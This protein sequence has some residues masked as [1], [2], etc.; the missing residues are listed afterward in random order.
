VA[1]RK[2]AFI[3]SA[4][5]L[6]GYPTAEGADAITVA[7]LGFE[8]KSSFGWFTALGQSLARLVETDLA[9]A[10][11]VRAV[12]R[13]QVDRV[14]QELALGSTG[15]LDPTQVTK[16]GQALPASF[17]VHGAL[18]AQ[19]V[20][21]GRLSDAKLTL[22]ARIRRTRD[23][24]VV[25]TF[26]SRAT[27][28]Q[29]QKLRDGLVAKVVDA[30]RGAE[31]M[32]RHTTPRKGREAE[33]GQLLKRA[34]A[35]RA[36]R[37]KKAE[38]KWV[39][40]A[41]FLAPHDPEV[42]YQLARSRR[43]DGLWIDGRPHYHNPRPGPKVGIHPYSDPEVI[44]WLR[45][46]VERHTSSQWFDDALWEIVHYQSCPIEPDVV[47]ALALKHARE[48]DWLG[49]IGIYLMTRT[50]SVTPLDRQ[51]AL[52]LCRLKTTRQVGADHL[53]WFSHS[54]GLRMFKPIARPTP[55]QAEIVLWLKELHDL[56][57]RGGHRRAVAK[58][59]SWIEGHPE[60]LWRCEKYARAAVR[61]EKDLED[62]A[63]AIELYEKAI[64]AAAE[65]RGETQRLKEGLD[66]FW[67]ST[68]QRYRQA[69]VK[70]ALGI[71]RCC[72]ADWKR[73]AQWAERAIAFWQE[74]ARD[75]RY[76]PPS[77]EERPIRK[78]AG[79]ARFMLGDY[80]GAYA[81]YEALAKL[82]RGPER[83]L[84]H[85][86]DAR[87]EFLECAGRLGRLQTARALLGENQQEKPGT[88]RVSPYRRC[89][90]GLLDT[91]AMVAWQGKL[92]CF[93]RPTRPLSSREPVPL[94]VS[95]FNP[96]TGARCIW[97][98]E[99]VQITSPVT[100][101]LLVRGKVW[102]STY[103][104]GLFVYDLV[105]DTWQSKDVSKGL[106]ENRVCALGLDE[107]GR[108]IWCTFR[109][110]AACYDLLKDEWR[111]FTHRNLRKMSRVYP[112]RGRVWFAA[113]WGVLTMDRKT[114]AFTFAKPRDIAAVPL[115]RQGGFTYWAKQGR[116][117]WRTDAQGRR[118]GPRLDVKHINVS[119]RPAVV[120]DILVF[121]WATRV[122]GADFG[123]RRVVP[124]VTSYLAHNRRNDSGY[125]LSL[126]SLGSTLYIGSGEGFVY[127]PDGTL[128]SASRS[129][130][131]P[132][133]L[134]SFDT[135]WLRNGDWAA[136]PDLLKQVVQ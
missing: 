51:I 101:A 131:N 120:K 36:K 62:A 23:G 127:H 100:D 78:E 85:G 83:W 107:L 58:I 39:T 71:V 99:E 37:D 69:R 31:R 7:I 55:R 2:T 118:D 113:G 124:I 88:D 82:K 16:L 42:L 32:A 79:H 45:E 12:E 103:G 112:G 84:R 18:D 114:G 4:L 93:V 64:T 132:V 48:S 102:L 28:G 87:R 135:E 77:F 11:G 24:R 46:V 106:L 10:D 75:F 133:A 125:S 17:H 57:A 14:L 80:P 61:C 27:A 65:H 94:W 98:V 21:G 3:I 49:H 90:F 122:F 9:R 34:V 5:L 115:L 59:L 130:D 40:A 35:A 96:A 89:T 129:A 1:S 117:V 92:Y 66:V 134:L 81:H 110:G 121:A 91:Q 22:T 8:N 95:E 15:L 116:Y 119:E 111:T 44:G 30:V 67:K 29:I 53:K 19:L 60:D 86:S 74:D 128:S 123:R 73:R 33:V 97:P 56:D 108:E 70:Y 68:I 104:Q 126:A 72:G 41:Y 109:Q 52:H 13:A 25:A 26:G 63:R 20:T 54:V 38:E 6:A 76:S 136:L 105:T 50:R 43:L 47:W